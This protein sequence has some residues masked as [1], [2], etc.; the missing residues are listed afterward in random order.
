MR[1]IFLVLISCILFSSCDDGDVITA[2]LNFEDDLLQCD[3]NSDS[4]LIYKTRVDP[5]E[6]LTVLIPR[7]T[8]TE[9]IFR[10]GT[11]E[12]LNTNMS[13]IRFNYRT[14]N[15][16]IVGD[17]LCNVVSPADLMI[18]EDYEADNGAEIIF[19]STIIDDDLD[20]IPSV[21]EGRGVAD[22]DGNFPNA[23]DSDDDTI[24]D[25]LD[26]DDDN[27]NVLTEDEI[28][29][30]NADGDDN[31]LTN[32]LDTDADGTPDYLDTDDDGDMIPT[33]EE[34]ENQNMRPTDDTVNTNGML[35]PF[36]LSTIENTSY[37]NPGLRTDNTYQRTVFTNILIQNFN[38]D[39]LRQDI[40]DMGIFEN[41][42]TIESF[43][44]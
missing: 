39:I 41:T 9:A 10:E 30:V 42:L 15:R 5:S 13:T 18:N 26:Q 33:I 20:G 6:S 7:N 25:Y 28:D 36:Y 29:E 17:E 38:I 31:P 34:D 43:D 27:D 3:N 37:G 21:D 24:P 1:N 35:V 4:F 2:E 22:A 32:P 11:S 23:Q 16:D 8:T 12:T 40:Y 19:N 14:Y 44:N